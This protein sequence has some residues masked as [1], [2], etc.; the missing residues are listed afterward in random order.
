M[1]AEPSAVALNGRFSGREPLTQLLCGAFERAARE[2][3]PELLIS[4]ATFEDWPLAD[5]ATVQSLQ[6]WV[7]PGRRLVMLAGRFD[8]VLRDQPRFVAWRKTNCH[9]IDCRI[10][11]THT[12]DGPPSAFCSPN[13]FLQRTDLEA[14]AGVYGADRR[15]WMAVRE[16]MLTALRTS[17]PGFPVTTLGL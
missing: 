17:R 10:S 5:A 8:R 12:S 4:D 2:G 13:W 14:C 9:M 11:P 15:R 3:W 7:R 16:I 1:A 6:A